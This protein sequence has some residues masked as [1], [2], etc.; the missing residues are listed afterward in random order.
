MLK[1]LKIVSQWI[2]SAISKTI[3]Q[4][5]MSSEEKIRLRHFAVFVVWGVATMSGFA[6]YNFMVGNLLVGALVFFTGSSLVFG[7][8]LMCHLPMGQIVYRVNGFLFAGLV[9]YLLLHGEEDTSKS[10]WMFTFPLILFFLTGKKEGMV[11]SLGLLFFSLFLLYF[12]IPGF[13]PHH[14]TPAFIIRFVIV[15]LFITTV[16]FWFEFFRDQYRRGLADEH[17]KQQHATLVTQQNGDVSVHQANRQLLM[18]LDSVDAHVYVVDVATYQILYMNQKMKEIFGADL[19][20]QLCWQAFRK[21]SQPCDDCT[22][23]RLKNTGGDL[24]ETVVWEGYNPISKRWYSNIDRMITWPDQRP[25]KLQIAFDITEKKQWET[26][27]QAIKESQNQVQKAEALGRMAGSIAHYYNNQLTAIIG[28]LQLALESLPGNV[29]TRSYLQNAIQVAIDSSEINMLLFQYLGQH[30]GELQPVDLAEFC[31]QQ[32]EALEKHLPVNIVIRTDLSVGGLIVYADGALLLQIL[33]QLVTN[34]REAMNGR[35]GE[36]VVSVKLVA[37]MALAGQ[38]L[39]PKNWRPSADSYCCLAISD[40]GSGISEENKGRI[41]DP[42]FTTKLSSRGL[43]LAVVLG[44]VKASGGAMAV[45]SDVQRG[46][47]VSIYL[48]LSEV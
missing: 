19:E 48:P 13:N 38:R 30:S 42:F 33:S 32:L 17:Q 28:N 14:Y 37:A 39:E 11:W 36:I 15:Y 16:T 20:G 46:C 5:P 34:S 35:G 29:P 45:T 21:S 31:A 10:L 41:F 8:L 47:V 18:I 26:E 12:P 23:P 24:E 44:I 3:E 6:I 9:L 25:V 40:T 22:I 2:L 7:W 43:G 1:P 27:Q 4:A